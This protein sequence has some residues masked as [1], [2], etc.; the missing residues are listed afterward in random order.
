MLV[1]RYRR[2]SWKPGQDT[3]GS[4]ATSQSPVMVGSDQWTMIEMCFRYSKQSPD[5][6]VFHIPR[7]IREEYHD[8]TRL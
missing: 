7:S 4:L 2:K 3:I 8:L 6:Y 5:E 1:H